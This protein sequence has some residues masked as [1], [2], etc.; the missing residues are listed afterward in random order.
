MDIDKVAIIGAGTMGGGIAITCLVAGL[1][2][3]AIDTAQEALAALEARVARFFDRAV[4]KERMTAQQAQEAR[5]CLSTSTR[6]DSAEPADLVIEAVFEDLAVKRALFDKLVPVLGPQTI[7][8]TN[9]SALRVDELAQTLPAPQRF[10]G[11][12]YFSPAEINPLVELVRG[13]RSGSDAMAAAKRFLE[14]TGRVILECRDSSGFVV[15]RFFCPYT[16]EAVRCLEDGQGRAAQIDEVGRDIFGLP[17]GPF[18]VM[19]IIKPRINLSALRNLSPLG[20]FYAPANE[21]VRVGEADESWQIEEAPQPLSAET[22]KAVGDRLRG[23]LFL[24]VL[25]AIGEEVATPEAVDIGAQQAL[26]FGAPP[27]AQMRELGRTRVEALLAPHLR[28]HGAVL[29]RAG[30]DRVFG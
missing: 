21:M 24:P 7:L 29:P 12:H 27:V 5:A 23:A 11:L 26:R 25:E 6:I 22:R 3:A 18:A 28:T 10:L 8:A 2:V 30:L 4:E 1:P 19:N 17:L 16:N 14:R 9:T 20:P 13:P 15:N